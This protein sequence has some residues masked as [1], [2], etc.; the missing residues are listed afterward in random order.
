MGRG[1]E[2]ERRA[3][4]VL[5]PGIPVESFCGSSGADGGE[6]E[7]GTCKRFRGRGFQWSRFSIKAVSVRG[8]WGNTGRGRAH[9]TDE[10]E[11][12]W[13]WGFQRGR[14]FSSRGAGK[15]TIGADGEG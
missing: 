15:E 2:H 7:G 8:R 13:V 11:S 5:G 4:D 10:R 3:Q 14:F 6:L 12:F 1:G 9:E